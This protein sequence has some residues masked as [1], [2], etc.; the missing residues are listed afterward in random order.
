MNDSF[1]NDIGV[2]KQ[3]GLAEVALHPDDAAAFGLKEGDE[4]K[5]SNETASLC[6]R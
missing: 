1:A 3:L 5:L 2:T 6:C 4:A